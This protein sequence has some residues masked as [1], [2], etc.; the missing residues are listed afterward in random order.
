MQIPLKMES[1]TL[2]IMYSSPIIVLQFLRAFVTRYASEV[3]SRDLHSCVSD[4]V[5]ILLEKLGDSNA[6]TREASSEALMFLASKKEIGL[7][8]VSIPLLRPTKNQVNFL[9]FKKFKIHHLHY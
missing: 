4:L 9:F 3:P 1:P 5:N 2:I 6:R 7:H 8:I